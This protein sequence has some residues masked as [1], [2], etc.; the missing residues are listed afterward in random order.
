MQLKSNLASGENISTCT[1]EKPI[2]PIKYNSKEI[3]RT[4]A[5]EL[6]EKFQPNATNQDQLK[7]IKEQL[8]VLFNKPIAAKINSKPNQYK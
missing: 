8:E 6:R 5:R 2:A 3:A 4:R 1:I 7:N